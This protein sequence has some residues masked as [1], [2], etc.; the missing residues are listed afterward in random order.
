MGHNL[1]IEISEATDKKTQPISIIM[2]SKVF[3]AAGA[4][5]LFLV[6]G[7]FIV[8]HRLRGCLL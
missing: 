3:A 8:S 7:E 6:L 4:A 5:G 1:L 2:Y